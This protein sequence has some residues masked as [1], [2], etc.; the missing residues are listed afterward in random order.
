VG[1]WRVLRGGGGD[2]PWWR[3]LYGLDGRLVLAAVTSIGLAGAFVRAIRAAGG[4]T[5]YPVVVDFSHVSQL[6]AR[7]RGTVRLLAEVFGGYLP[8]RHGPLQIALGVLHL[9]G[10]PLVALALLVVAYRAVRHGLLPG[11]AD[12]VSAL[13]AVGAVANLGAYL[14]STLPL[15]I[16]GSREVVAVLPLGAALAGRVFGPSLTRIRV[17]RYALAG[18]LAVMCVAFTAQAVTAP[19]PVAHAVGQQQADWLVANGYT[20]GLGTYWESNSITL[21]SRGRVHV[22]P[23]QSGGKFSAYHWESRAGWYD[24]RHHDAR[25]LLLDLRAVSPADLSRLSTQFGPPARTRQFSRYSV[26]Y[27]YDHNILAALK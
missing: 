26:A 17:G 1:A 10:L 8:D 6:P 24:P 21:A 14:V 3:R 23:V 15:D 25:F 18:V 9:A 4:F 20:Y 7:A 16:N 12:R 19:G 13:L 11:G 2:R 22:A 27:L 5:V